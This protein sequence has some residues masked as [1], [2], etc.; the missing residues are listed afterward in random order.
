MFRA[1]GR[2]EKWDKPAENQRAAVVNRTG[3]FLEAENFD[4]PADTGSREGGEVWGPHE[5]ERS[6]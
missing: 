3:I 2:G 6:T 1:L 5:S 4:I